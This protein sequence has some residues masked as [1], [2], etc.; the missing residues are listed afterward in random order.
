L[1]R[2]EIKHLAAT[3]N[4]RYQSEFNSYF[5]SMTGVVDAYWALEE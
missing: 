5:S 4:A 2:K 3:C 1:I